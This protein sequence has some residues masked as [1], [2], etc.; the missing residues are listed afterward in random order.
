MTQEFHLIPQD[1]KDHERSENCWCKPTR[2]V[3]GDTVTWVHEVFRAT[4]EETKD[5]D[6]VVAFF[7]KATGEKAHYDMLK[8]ALG[9]IARV[10]VARDGGQIVGMVAYA[11]VINPFIGQQGYAVLVDLSNGHSLEIKP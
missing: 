10:M 1:T 6:E 9:T 4:I 8:V 11:T 7:E 2:S 3:D 5:L